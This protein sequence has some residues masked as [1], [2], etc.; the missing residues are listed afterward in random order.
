MYINDS[1]LPPIKLSDELYH[2][3]GKKGPCYVLNYGEGLALIDTSCPDNMDIIEPNIKELGFSLSDVHHIFHSHGHFDHYGCTNDIVRLT[4]AVTY[5]SEADLEYFKG[6]DPYNEWGDRISFTPDVLLK[7]GD[8]ITLGNYDIR[9]LHTPG[10]T[11]GVLSI[12]LTLHVDG[13]PYLGG[14]F[15]GSGVKP[16]YNGYF[17][18][19]EVSKSLRRKMIASID[20]IITEPVKIHIGNHLGNNNAIEKLNY[21][22]DGNPFLIYNNYVEFLTAKRAQVL[23][24]IESQENQ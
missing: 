23:E 2:V 16:L 3:G 4:G 15:G 18:D 1:F 17:S 7:D 13:V 19:D 8:I 5:G 6:G 9:F 24:I 12:F 10:H 14:M 21:T 20:R 22:G 11:E